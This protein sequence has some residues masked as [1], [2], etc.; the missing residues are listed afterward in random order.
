MDVNFSGFYVTNVAGR[1]VF[2]SDETGEPLWLIAFV[3]D[4]S[5][6]PKGEANVINRSDFECVRAGIGYFFHEDVEN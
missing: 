1:F 4:S 2:S 6:I 5:K 3:A